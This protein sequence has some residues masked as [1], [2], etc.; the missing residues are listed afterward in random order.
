M[1]ENVLIMVIKECLI[2]LDN[3]IKIKI[4]EV[5]EAVILVVI[6]EEATEITIVVY[7]V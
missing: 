5:E 4:S 1:T 2:D 7:V 3:E 6:I